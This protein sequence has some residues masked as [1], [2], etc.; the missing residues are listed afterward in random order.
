MRKRMSTYVSPT[1]LSDG[2]GLALLARVQQV[3]RVERLLQ[4][5]MQVVADG[6]ELPL[7]LSALQPADSVLPGDGSAEM[8][9]ELEELVAG[10]ISAPL[11]VGVVGREE[12][13]R[14]DVA[15]ARVSERERGNAMALTD[16][17]RLTRHLAQTV[18]RHGNVLAE[19]SAALSEDCERGTRAPPPEL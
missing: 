3:L 13:G 7:E 14:V 8:E 16:L 17:E 9:R 19:G 12:E 2:G 11:L 5:R 15:V 4:P 10:G 18:E 6:T 1:S